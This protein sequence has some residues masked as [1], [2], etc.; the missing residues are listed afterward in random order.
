[1]PNF[2]KTTLGVTENVNNDE[3]LLFSFKNFIE[4]NTRNI[5]K[6]TSVNGKNLQPSSDPENKK[7]FFV[8]S[9]SVFGGLIVY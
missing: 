4:Q 8:V 3:V 9:V 2:L 7:L 1:M 6:L 5:L